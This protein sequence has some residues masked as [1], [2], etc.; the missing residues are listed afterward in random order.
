MHS[1]AF[2]TPVVLQ[3]TANS[4]SFTPRKPLSARNAT[5]TPL[6]KMAITP[7]ADIFQNRSQTREAK[8][9]AA[10]KGVY[11]VQC[12]EGT[13]GA[14][15]AE[16]SRLSSLARSFRLRQSSASARYADLFATRRAAVIAAAGSHVEESYAVR[17]PARAAATVASRAEKLR[18]CS[19]YID[20]ADEAEQYMFQCVDNQYNALKVPG[21]VYSVQACNA[22]QSDDVDTARVCAGAA[23]FRSNQ[24]SNS[25]KT[26]Q[27]YNASLEA[28]YSGRGCTYEEDEYMNF[29]K[30]AGAIRW[31][32]G[33][34][35][36]SVSSV[37][38]AMNVRVP[39]VTERI[40]GVNRDSFWP[41][42]KIREAVPRKDP[43]WKAPSVKN[44]APMSAA[45]LQYGIDAQTKQPELPSYDSWKPGW[46][47]KSSIKL[48]PYER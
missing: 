22:R 36:A 18:A 15:T 30:M 38:G 10:S 8:Q 12:T 6:V 3:S 47:P 46:A 20:A 2:T 25:Q 45:A 27:R 32:T 13:A 23:V 42:Y 24:L 43:V 11:T 33:A 31:S 35:A 17:F 39:S 41:S 28:I 29:P 21:G 40:Q 26:Q 44:Y 14:N 1:A 9:S 48:S 16:Y 34:Y 7:I 19:R 5:S 4:S 37:Q